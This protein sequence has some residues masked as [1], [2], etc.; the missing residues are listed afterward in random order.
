MQGD[1]GEEG[2]ELRLAIGSRLR[3]CRTRTHQKRNEDEEAFHAAN[4]F[5]CGKPVCPIV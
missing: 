5:A 3:D 1:G 4:L 2:V